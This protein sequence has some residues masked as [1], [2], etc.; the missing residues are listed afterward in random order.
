ME[1]LLEFCSKGR[2]NLTKSAIQGKDEVED[3]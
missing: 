3:I 1:D 2:R